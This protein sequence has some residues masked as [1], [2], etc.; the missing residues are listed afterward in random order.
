[1]VSF[2]LSSCMTYEKRADESE[3]IGDFS[4]G[5][6]VCKQDGKEFFIDNSGKRVSDRYD[7]L[8][9]FKN[10]WA[11]AFNYMETLTDKQFVLLDSMLVVHSYP[12]YF[13]YQ[14]VNRH[15][16]IW[17]SLGDMRALLNVHTGYLSALFPGILE[18]VDDSG[19]AVARRRNEDYTSSFALF[20]GTGKEVVPFDMYTYIGGFH[21]GMAQY[22]TTGYIKWGKSSL[23]RFNGSISRPLTGFINADGK[24]VVKE[25]F[26]RA[27]DFNSSGYAFVE[28]YRISKSIPVPFDAKDKDF[29]SYYITKNGEIA[30]GDE[31]VVAEASFLEDG[32]WMCAKDNEGNYYLLNNKLNK[33][34]LDVEGK[35]SLSRAIR[36]DDGS[37][38][39]Y[40][41]SK[42]GRNYVLY[43][44]DSSGSHNKLFDFQGSG[45]AGEIINLTEYGGKKA[46]SIYYGYK[47]D[48]IWDSYRGG[49]CKY[50]SLSDGTCLRIEQPGGMSSFILGINRLN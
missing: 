1:M 26:D 17:V 15:G 38:T 42:N 10:G 23:S 31:A 6:A 32:V 48:E 21:N 11:V 39:Q 44:I 25:Q 5:Y 14:N 18:Y 2:F 7:S 29:I 49:Y 4:Y 20:D 36:T 33:K 3:W 41:L 16:N 40:L 22:S 24:I 34:I 35:L 27:S 47:Y 8:R 9:T 50:Y 37:S 30:I 19:L 46:L 28:K 12:V 43:E 13:M 45:Y